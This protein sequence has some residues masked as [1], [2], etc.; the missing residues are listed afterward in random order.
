MC[1]VD[2]GICHIAELAYTTC[3]VSPYSCVIFSQP[4]FI[5]NKTFSIELSPFGTCDSNHHLNIGFSIY[6]FHL[7]ETILRITPHTVV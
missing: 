5:R 6:R 7:C 2:Q 4:L 3:Y 1:Y